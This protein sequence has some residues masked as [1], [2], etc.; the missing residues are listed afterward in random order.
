VLFH[1][2]VLEEEIKGKNAKAI[3]AF[4]EKVRNTQGIDFVLLTVRDGLMMMRKTNSK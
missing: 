4:N 2:E 3:A 1:G